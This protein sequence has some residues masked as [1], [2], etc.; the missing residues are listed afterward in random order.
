MKNHKINAIENQVCD[1]IAINLF[2]IIQGLKKMSN[3]KLGSYDGISY[4]YADSVTSSYNSES[5][6]GNYESSYSGSEN[7]RKKR[8]STRSTDETLWQSQ[9][10]RNFTESISER[11]FEERVIEGIF[12]KLLI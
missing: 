9:F 2:E 7:Y 4:E 1:L 10:C 8:R 11:I 12:R 3:Y 5:Y 6:G